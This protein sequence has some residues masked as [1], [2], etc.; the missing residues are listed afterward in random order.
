MKAGVAGAHGVWVESISIA[1]QPGRSL[2][3]SSV[4]LSFT[5]QDKPT[6]LTSKQVR[7]GLDSLKELH[8]NG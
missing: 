1:S 8:S 7:F 2:S 4:H 3:T 5:R 6:Y